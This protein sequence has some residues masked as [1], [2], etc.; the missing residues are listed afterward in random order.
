MRARQKLFQVVTAVFVVVMTGS[1]GYYILFGGKPRFMDCVYMTVISLTSVGY[2][3]VLEVTGNT[4]A[5]IFTMLII[6]FGMGIILY[7]ISAMTAVLIEG[8]LSGYLR[9]RKMQKQIQKLKGHHIVCGGGETGKPLVEELVKNREKVVLIEMDQNKIDQFKYSKRLFHVKGD[10]T[11]DKNLFKAGIDQAAGLIICLPVDKDTLFVTMSARMINSDIRIIS[12]MVDPKL[13]PKLM[14][15][16]ADRVVSP[17]F[18]GAL[19][20][21]SE[22]IRPTVVNFLDTMLRS[23]QG[24]LRIHQLTISKGSPAAGKKIAESG[25]RDKYGLLVLGSKEE[26]Q[27]IEFNPPPFYELKEGM[28]I[29]V[30]GEMSDIERARM[31]F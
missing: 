28:A 5:Q 18:I 26:G 12:R 29:I 9:E 20:M 16:G 10:A 27:N 13:E 21:A 23:K 11:E 14:R 2:G 25:I 1:T 19:R 17:N 24:T 4:A 30:M 7:A 3:E 6:T 22:I 8:E 15:A 31:D